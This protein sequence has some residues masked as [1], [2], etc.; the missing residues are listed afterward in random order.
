VDN[1]EAALP[2]LACHRFPATFFIPTAYT[3]RSEAFWWDQL[4]DLA[5]RSAGGA[6]TLDVTIDGASIH[7]S[8]ADAATWAGQST[9]ERGL[10]TV[11]HEQLWVLDEGRRDAALD[12]VAHRLSL[13]RRRHTDGRPMSAEELVQLSRSPLVEIGAHTMTH[14]HLP[15]LP[16]EQK[17]AEIS[18]SCDALAAL[19]G[20][21]PS[22]FAYPYGLYDATSV[23]LVK[24]AGIRHACTAEAELMWSADDDHAI[25][26]GVVFDWSGS[27]FLRRLRWEC[28][29]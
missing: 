6:R 9:A 26:R 24:E 1:L 29:L 28:L 27:Q 19:L 5:S 10:L 14:C 17:R 20:K 2:S 7:W 3:G 13:E 16:L 12:E 25:P 11:L 23:A 21:A 18:G 15:S 4:A 8:Y 22:S